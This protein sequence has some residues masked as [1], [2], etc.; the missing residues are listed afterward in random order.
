MGAGGSAQRPKSDGLMDDPTRMYD[1]AHLQPGVTSP[2]DPMAM[3]QR[4]LVQQHGARSS[5]ALTGM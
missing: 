1:P 2:Y 3:A 5:P 4:S